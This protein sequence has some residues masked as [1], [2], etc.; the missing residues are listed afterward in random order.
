MNAEVRSLDRQR[1]R[2]RLWSW[3]RYSVAVSLAITLIYVVFFSRLL[4]V[5]SVTVIGNYYA[6]EKKIL[7]AANIEPGT[8]LAR[9]DSAAITAEILMLP[10]VKSVEIRRA[11]P[12]EVI[13][14]IK[15]RTP[16]AVTKDGDVWRYVS[17]GGV[18]FGLSTAKPEQYLSVRGIN[19]AT[20]AEAAKVA[21]A[22]PS[23]LRDRVDDVQ[24]R[25]VDDVAVWLNNGVEIRWGSA[26]Q[27]EAKSKTLKALMGMRAQMYNVSVPDQPTIRQ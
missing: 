25:S 9:L 27:S 1:R 3:L 18:V 14:A 17:Q 23:W 26:E 19:A 6:S 11:W 22:L 20:F 10:E 21:A 4:S 7:H 15:E 8:Q 5:T 24:G 12:H 2:K 16:M 13:L